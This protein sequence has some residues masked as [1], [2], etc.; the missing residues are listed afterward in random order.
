M[1]AAG[2]L[3]ASQVLVA[4]TVVVAGGVT[5][6]VVAYQIAFTFFLLPHAVLA[7]PVYT[8]LYPR[9]ARDAADG[10]MAAFADDMAAGLRTLAF[11]LL[12]AAAVLAALAE[13]LLRALSFGALGAGD[14]VLVATGLAAYS[15]GL[16]GYSYGFLLTRGSYACGDVRT[17]TIVYG[18]ACLAGI[19]A[20][21]VVA[22][23]LDG[24][25]RLLA[26]GLVHAAVVTV[27][28][29]VLLARV[30]HRA[31]QP[32]PV[33]SGLL[34]AGLCAGV[35]GAAAWAVA[36][37]ID[38][39]SRAAALA[40][41]ALGGIA[42]LAALLAVAYPTRSLAAGLELFQSSRQRTGEGAAA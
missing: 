18:A 8:V 37:A 35:A 38:V 1:W 16:L 36:G 42:A 22:G 5:G 20:M 12:P 3:G 33:A 31:G 13:P 10:R 4:V 9:L 30:A 40:A 2:H 29:A 32:I 28:S 25:D 21:I 11:L 26:L 14:A 19:V 15:A 23:G 39:E 27:A 41:C 24:S 7:N 17:P 34:R 6:G